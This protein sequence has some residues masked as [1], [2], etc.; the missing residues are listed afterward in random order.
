MCK[1][2]RDDYGAF[3]KWAYEHGY[4]DDARK[5]QCTLDRI[6]NEKGYS[7]ENC[8]FVNNQE[9]CNNR[10]NN[11][12][13]TI[14]EVTHTIQEWSHI[15]GIPDYIIRDRINKLHWNPVEAVLTPRLP[16]GVRRKLFCTHIKT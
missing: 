6:D 1:E 2:W 11:K 4:D 15:V 12:R 10:R 14:G 9:Q 8:R 5:Y 16:L 13:I 7:P 3:E